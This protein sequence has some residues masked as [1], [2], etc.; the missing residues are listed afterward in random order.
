MTRSVVPVVAGVALLAW[1][2][3]A[4]AEEPAAP[5]PRPADKSTPAAVPHA[6]TAPAG[7]ITP[8]E[9]DRRIMRWIALDNRGFVE[10]SEVA[11]DRATREDV[12]NFARRMA[13]DHR[14]FQQMFGAADDKSF[15]DRAKDA[16]KSDTDRPLVGR[17]GAVRTPPEKT[18]TLVQDDGRSRDG[19][20]AF[21]PTDFVEVK[22]K[23]CSELR[24]DAKRQF[25]ALK[26]SDFDHAYLAHMR[27]GHQMMLATIDAVKGTAS[28]DLQKKLEALHEDCEQHLEQ[29]KEL[30]KTSTEDDTSRNTRTGESDN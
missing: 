15:L 14:K 11:R 9:N 17:P 21:R 25:E 4:I 19:G 7:I 16:A 24:N 12:K 29:V 6:R 2:A 1:A 18:A 5:K 26:G 22:E 10:F 20:L 30:Q 3:W 28:E 23:V 27:I 13:D 8:Q